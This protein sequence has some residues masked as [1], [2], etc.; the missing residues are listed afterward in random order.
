M[1]AES[2]PT[3]RIF[4]ISGEWRLGTAIGNPSRSWDETLSR[5]HH[6]SWP[7]SRKVFG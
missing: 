6:R 1:D 3:R 4:D 7:V 5:V 2:A